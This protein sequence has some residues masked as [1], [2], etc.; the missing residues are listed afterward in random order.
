MACF[1]RRR[2]GV[3]VSARPPSFQKTYGQ[4][5][6]IVMADFVKMAAYFS[7]TSRPLRQNYPALCAA[8][9]EGQGLSN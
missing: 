8:T 5:M 2:S 4:A 6:H 1:T 9:S 7:S 3:R